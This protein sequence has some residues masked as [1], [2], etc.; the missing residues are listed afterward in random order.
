MSKNHKHKPKRKQRGT[1][2]GFYTSERL[3]RR[4]DRM[5]K[6]L[7]HTRAMMMRIAVEDY[8]DRNEDKK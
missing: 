3:R 8:L 2:I 6:L 1:L 4:I 7:R 5:A